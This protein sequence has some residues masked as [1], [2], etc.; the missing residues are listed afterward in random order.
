MRNQETK[1]TSFTN[2]VSL[3]VY[4]AKGIRV[5]LKNK[6]FKEAMMLIWQSPAF[7]D[8]EPFK[9]VFSSTGKT[10]YADKA[11]FISYLE[12]EITQQQ[13]IE[14]TACDNVFRNTKELVT[15]DNLIIDEGSLWKSKNNELTLIDDDYH[16]TAKMNKVLF[17]IAE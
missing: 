16:L 4:Y 10:L 2:S 11:Q 6:T 3:K 5:S 17:E 9:I 13:L 12:A 15:D 7:C 1:E 8:F 14:N